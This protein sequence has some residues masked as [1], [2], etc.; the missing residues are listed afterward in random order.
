[1]IIVKL[2]LK[3]IIAQKK[4]IITV[5]SDPIPQNNSAHKRLTHDGWKMC[6]HNLKNC[7]HM[8]TSDGSHELLYLYFLDT[9]A[10]QRHMVTNIHR[11]GS[12]LTQIMA[13]CLMASSHYLIQYWLVTNEVLWHSPE[14]KITR[15]AQATLLYI[16]FENYTF[17]IIG[18][19]PRGQWVK[20]TSLQYYK[21]WLAIFSYYMYQ[22]TMLTNT[23]LI[24]CA[25][26]C[27]TWATCRL[28]AGTTTHTPDLHHLL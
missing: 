28:Y 20:L 17:K 1:M 25:N 13:C 27:F 3:N 9:V 23:M 18:L 14:R 10:Q 7:L 15:S 12:T 6:N 21:L 22:Q 2:H 26:I 8:K 16:K 24:I 19:S 4:L 5:K 11:S